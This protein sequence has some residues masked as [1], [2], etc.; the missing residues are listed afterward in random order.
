MSL[1][2]TLNTAA[3]GLG[4]SGTRLAII[5]DNIANI[6]TVGFK[7]ARAQFADLVARLA[8]PLHAISYQPDNVA[9]A[10]VGCLMVNGIED[11]PAALGRE[12]TRWAL[13]DGDI[14]VDG[15]LALD[16]LKGHGHTACFMVGPFDRLAPPRSVRYA[17]DA[18]GASVDGVDKRWLLID[19]EHGASADYGHA[20]LVMGRRAAQDVFRPLAEF[21]AG[22]DGQD[23]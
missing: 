9:P 3:S 16:E 17:Y 22:H 20:D 12:M 21:L 7:A 8:T 11:V 14:R 2:S 13:S 15:R 5:G 1:F 4:V 6:N 23:A 19:R 18:W 10:V